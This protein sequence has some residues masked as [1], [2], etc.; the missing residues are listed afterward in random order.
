MTA[1]SAADTNERPAG[2][3]RNSAVCDKNTRRGDGR[4][5]RSPDTTHSMP[6]TPTNW[7]AA[8][9]RRRTGEVGAARGALHHRLVVHEAGTERLRHTPSVGAVWLLVRCPSGGQRTRS[10]KDLRVEAQLEATIMAG[11]PMS[12]VF[13]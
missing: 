10:R 12:H 9:T 2:N 8:P 5:G 7:T 11:L 13:G 1:A 3:C 4:G 6:K